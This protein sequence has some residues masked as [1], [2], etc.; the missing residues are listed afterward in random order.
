[1][2]AI[3]SAHVAVSYRRLEQVHNRWRRWLRLRRAANWTLRG[4]VLGLAIGLAVSLPTVLSRSL[5]LETYLRLLTASSIGGGLLAAALALLW[6]RSQFESARLFDRSLRLRERLSTAV[7]LSSAGWPTSFDIARWQLEDTLEACE[8]IDV[9]AG[10][11]I[12]I[13]RREIALVG[14]LALAAVWLRHLGRDAFEAAKR[15]ETVERAISAEAERVELIQEQLSDIEPLSPQDRQSLLEP[16]EALGSQLEDAHSA[17]QALSALTAGEAELRALSDPEA[18]EASSRLRQAGE[19]LSQLPGAEWSAFGRA[20]AEGDFEAAAD[21]LEDMELRS[22][23]RERA[24]RQA[25]ELEAAAETLQA[26]APELAAA[27]RDAASALRGADPL[28][29][30]EAMGEAARS[31]RASGRE[32]L[33][34]EVATRIANDLAAAQARLLQA[35]RQVSDPSLAAQGQPTGGAGGEGEGQGAGQGS[36]GV[37]G[38][39]DGGEAGQAVGGGAGQGESEG[40]SSPGAVAGTNPISQDNAPGDGGERPYQPIQPATLLGTEGGTSLALPGSGD[41]GELIL[42]SADTLPLAEGETRVAYTEVLERYQVTARL[43]IEDLKPPP[44][45]E[46]LVHEY[47]TALAP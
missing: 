41:P 20:L 34:A 22:S 11:P 17:E 12:R 35:A 42:G 31:L 3:E 46:G 28:A 43:A 38:D 25:R 30:G 37:G 40:G 23:T 4:V 29:A 16:L 15:R 27:L 5:V 2:Q 8:R 45:F 47:F 39:G 33:Q 26:A 10:L 7:E 1:M 6:P 19:S 24:E 13:S 32:I 18:L 44:Y 21:I 36:A 14:L 9:R